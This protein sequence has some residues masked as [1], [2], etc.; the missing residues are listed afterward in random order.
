M[1]NR[2]IAAKTVTRSPATAAAAAAA[3]ASLLLMTRTLCLMTMSRRIWHTISLVHPSIH[4]SSSSSRNSSSGGGGGGGGGGGSSSSGNNNSSGSSGSSSSSSLFQYQK[5]LP[6]Q[7]QQL[8][9]TTLTL[10]GELALQF[11]DES[12]K[13]REEGRQP[14][15]EEESNRRLFFGR[16]RGVDVGSIEWIYGM[17]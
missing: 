16:L 10:T 8:R 13:L 4:S 1:L 15:N 5:L 17:N 2:L 14:E 9:F 12:M 11:P 3:A 6:R 7:P